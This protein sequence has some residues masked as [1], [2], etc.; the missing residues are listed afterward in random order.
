MTYLVSHYINGVFKTDPTARL[1]PI[2]NPAVGKIIGHV[3][4]GTKA[5]CD[6]A[7]LVAEKAQLAWAEIS[8]VRRTEILFRFRQCFENRQADLVNLVVREQGKTKED[9]KGSVMRALELISHH[10]GLL[11]Q[12]QGTLTMNVASHV[13]CFTMRQPLGVCVGVSPFNFPVM[14][15]IW[16]MIPAIAS[17]NAFI[18]KPSEQDPS[19]SIILLD[20]LHEAGVPP[21]VVN[22]VQGDRETVQ[23]L[24]THPKVAAVTAVASTSV[25]EAIYQTA[26]L[27]GKRAHTFGGAKNHA[28]VMPDADLAQTASAIVGAAYGAAGERC[29]AISV[30]VAVGDAT[31]DML[32]SKMQPLIA[33]IRLNAGDEPLCD[34]GPLISAAHRE[35]VLAAIDVGIKEGAKLVMDGRQITVPAYP[36]GFFLGPCLFDEVTPKM[37]I[38][39]QECFGPVLVLLRVPDLE[40]A[41][42][43]VNA[44]PYGNGAA[45]FTRDGY[46][47][48]E[49]VK[50][51]QVG[52][53]GINIPI[54]VPITSH[55]FGGWKRSVFG[56]TMMHGL[57]SMHFYTRSKSVTSRWFSQMDTES[58]FHMPTNRE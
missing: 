45:I 28:V 49:Y 26:V 23:A 41:L 33:A 21:G 17:G 3:S 20:L 11:M 55:P 46:T 30:V 57:E 37:S 32:L 35:R 7:V 51:V 44:H 14:V 15:P 36:Q 13:D 56:D 38:Y 10:C 1:S 19:P 47:A 31:A 27:A 12:H 25:A 24:I 4:V 5:I 50:R 16:M 53:V 43:L 22:I 6:E 52:M 58:A 40:T 29:M 8:L 39:Q 54:P 2:Y 18:L 48:H 9:A 42:A 34:M